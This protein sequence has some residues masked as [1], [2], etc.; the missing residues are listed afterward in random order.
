MSS[1]VK[2]WRRNT[3]LKLIACMGNDCQICGYNKSINALEFHHLDPDQKDFTIS[4]MRSNPKSWLKITKELKKCILVC[5]NC[6]RE[7][8]ENITDI[9]DTFQ[10]FDE[11]IL[12][13]DK[14]KHLLKETKT[15][16]CPVCNSIKENHLI[17]CSHSCASRRRNGIDWS[18]YDI[19]DLKDNKGLTNI[20]I[21]KIVGCSDV[22]I[23]KRYKKLKNN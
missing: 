9:P 16:Y 18:L 1:E 5:A 7:I 13:K 20:A 22:A 6:H 17:T 21:A 23:G 15:T 8:H 10:I 14:F 2:E 11:N 3:K 19:V 4:K 12:K